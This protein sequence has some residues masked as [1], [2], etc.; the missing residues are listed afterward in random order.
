MT[1]LCKNKEIYVRICRAMRFYWIKTAVIDSYHIA[2]C[3]VT[4]F[5]TH[6]YSSEHTP[7]IFSDSFHKSFVLFPQSISR[8]KARSVLHH[9]NRRHFTKYWSFLGT[10]V[11]PNIIKGTKAVCAASEKRKDDD[12]IWYARIVGKDENSMNVEVS[13]SYR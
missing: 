4:L 7:F 11:R 13:E 5:V 8:A 12:K 6:L 10:G 1:D 2:L 9:L 3:R